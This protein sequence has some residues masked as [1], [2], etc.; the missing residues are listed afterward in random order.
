[1]A[2]FLFVSYTVYN[3][4]EHIQGLHN[5]ILFVFLPAL[6]LDVFLLHL[7]EG[8]DKCFCKTCIGHQRNIVVYCT[9]TDTITVC[10]LTFRVIFR[11]VDYQVKLMFGYH[12]HYVVFCMR[13]FIWPEYRHSSSEAFLSPIFQFLRLLT[14]FLKNLILRLLRSHNPLLRWY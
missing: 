10:Q 14:V 9:T 3:F 7:A 4:S 6:Y 8:F 5:L 12:F 1:M 13:T 11:N 2:V